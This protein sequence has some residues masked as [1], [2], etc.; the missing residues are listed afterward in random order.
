MKLGSKLSRAFSAGVLLQLAGMCMVV[1]G[2]GPLC[3]SVSS[4]VI[5]HVSLIALCSPW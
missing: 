2:E 3:C 5:V 1:G 4:K